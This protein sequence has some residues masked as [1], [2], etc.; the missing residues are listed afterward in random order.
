MIFASVCRRPGHVLR[1]GTNL[2]FEFNPLA[3]KGEAPREACAYPFSE[4]RGYRGYIL[5]TEPRTSPTPP[6]SLPPSSPPLPSPTLSSPGQRSGA[7]SK[8]ESRK[9]CGN[10]RWNDPNERAGHIPRRQTSEPEA[11][12]ALNDARIN[13][14][15]VLTSTRSDRTGSNACLPGWSRFVNTSPPLSIQFRQNK[16]EEGGENFPI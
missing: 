5:P 9:E 4:S 6:P 2:F 7:S 14:G 3:L 1:R 11:C 12:L 8:H 13:G 16:F 10:F 15:S